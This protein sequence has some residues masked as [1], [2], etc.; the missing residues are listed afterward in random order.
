MGAL[1]PPGTPPRSA[2]R[3]RARS[4]SPRSGLSQ[5]WRFVLPRTPLN[6]P[7]RPGRKAGNKP[8]DRAVP[9]LP[10]GAL[11]PST[12]APATSACA[13]STITASGSTTVWASGTT[14]EESLA[15]RGPGDALSE[16]GSHRPCSPHGRLAGMGILRGPVPIL[17]GGA[18][19]RD[20]PG[21]RLRW[22]SVG[23]ESST[24]LAQRKVGCLMGWPPVFS[25]AVCL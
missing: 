15:A 7:D 4:P 24:E 12:A 22:P 9:P 17:C 6:R 16:G 25:F 18:A 21:C 2:C 11:A 20:A 1:P 10:A 23:L 13:V 19:Q 14:G 8:A 3:G 5:A